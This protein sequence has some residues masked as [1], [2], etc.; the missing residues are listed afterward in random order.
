[1]KPNQKLAKSLALSSRVIQLRLAFN[2]PDSEIA[3]VTGY[4]E[5]HIRDM[6]GLA[7]L[8]PG[9][10]A[11]RRRGKR[12]SPARC[13]TQALRLASGSLMLAGSWFDVFRYEIF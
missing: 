8:S 3:E 12:G 9:G 11:Y 1:M 5:R 7:G 6:R 4:S 2:L 10:D 13:S